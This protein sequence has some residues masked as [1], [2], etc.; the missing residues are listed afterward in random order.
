MQKLTTS[1]IIIINNKQEVLLV[2]RAK[3]ADAGDLW[4]LP[5]GTCEEG[6]NKEDTL[7]RETQEELGC[8]LFSFNFFRS[9]ETAT[10]KKSV[11][12]HYFF[13]TIKSLIV[14]NKIELSEYDWFNKS[15]IPINLAFNQNTVLSEF[16]KNH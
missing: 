10:L 4:S 6:E 12:A 2:K 11:I 5:G 8:S 14:L 1:N 13:G 16:W 3:G 15:N 9:F 7:I